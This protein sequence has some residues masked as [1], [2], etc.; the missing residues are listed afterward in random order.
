MYLDYVSRN[1]KYTLL[2]VIIKKYIRE[3]ILFLQY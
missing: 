1:I 2:D 3:Y